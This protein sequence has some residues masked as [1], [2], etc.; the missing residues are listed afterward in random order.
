M[1]DK[2]NHHL[3]Y[4]KGLI[5][6]VP[7]NILKKSI[8]VFAGMLF[9]LSC[10]N[11]NED[12]AAFTE[13]EKLPLLIS[14]DI[15][16]EY[17]DSARLKAKVISPMLKEYGSPDNYTVLPQ[18]VD[19]YFYDAGGNVTST[20]HADSAIMHRGSDM[21]EAYRN[22]VVQ[23]MDGERLETEQLFWRNS[24]NPAFRELTSNTFVTIYK[25]DEVLL[26]DGLKANESFTKYRILKPQGNFYLDENAEKPGNNE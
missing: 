2:R 15:V 17:S 10:G 3:S 12:I 22:V 19:V 24:P 9:L 26:G 5:L 20:M 21:M 18:G 11:S 8:P 7:V 13:K 25:G 23:N 1:L 4:Q 14:T 6:K 16:I